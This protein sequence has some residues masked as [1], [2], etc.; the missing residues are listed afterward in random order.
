[1]KMIYTVSDVDVLERLLSFKY[2]L[3]TSSWEAIINPRSL[4]ITQSLGKEE[5]KFDNNKAADRFAC[6]TGH[7]TN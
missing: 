7:M 5:D 2:F 1:M 4:T 3:D 6:L